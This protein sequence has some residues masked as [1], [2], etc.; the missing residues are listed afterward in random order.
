MSDETSNTTPILD[1]S[2]VPL[3]TARTVRART[4]LFKQTM[5]FLALN[6]RLLRMVRKGHVSR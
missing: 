2:G 5:R 4:S 1:M 3:P 6:L